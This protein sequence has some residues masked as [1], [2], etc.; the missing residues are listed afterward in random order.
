MF[1]LY[2]LPEENIN[3]ILRILKILLNF[4]KLKKEMI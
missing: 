3:E 2:N 4:E 1:I